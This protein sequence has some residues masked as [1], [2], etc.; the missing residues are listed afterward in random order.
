MK[1]YHLYQIRGFQKMTSKLISAALLSVCLFPF[2][3]RANQNPENPTGTAQGLRYKFYTGSTDSGVL[4]DFTALSPVKAGLI[5]NFLLDPRTTDTNIAFEYNGYVNCP[6]TGTWTFYTSSDDGSKLFIGGTQVVD[7]NFSQG[8]YERSGTIALNA[9]VHAIKVQWAQGGGALGLEVRYQGPSGTNPARTQIPNEALSCI[10]PTANPTFSPTNNRIMASTVTVSIADITPG[11]VIYYTTNGTTPTTSSSVYSAPLGPLTI[12]VTVKAIAKAPNMD[13]SDVVTMN[14]VT[15]FP[16]ANDNFASAALLTGAS[17]S[18]TGTNLNSSWESGEPNHGGGGGQRSIWY[19]WV[20][21]STGNFLISTASSAIDT[22]LGVYTGSAVNALTKVADNDDAAAGNSTSYVTIAAVSGTAYYFAID[23]FDGAE[24]STQINIGPGQLIS[25]TASTPTASE[26]TLSS[27][28]FTV[29][30][31]GN[32]AYPVTVYFDFSGTADRGLDFKRIDD[33]VIFNAGETVKTVTI[34]PIDDLIQEGN[35][36]VILT[37]LPSPQFA[38]SAAQKTATVTI[39]DNETGLSG[40]VK[41]TAFSINRGFYSAP[42][43]VAITTATAGASINYTLDGTMPTPTTGNSYSAPLHITSTT[44]LRAIAF[45]SGM[46][47][48]NVDTQTY[49]FTADIITQSPGGAPPPGWPLT[50]G[51]NVK[52]Y[53]MDQSVVSANSATIQNDIKTLPSFCVSIKLADLFDPNTGIY[54]NPSQDGYAWERPC[55]L[56]LIDPNNSA[57]NMGALCG[58]RLRGGFSRD[59]GNPKHAFRIFFR[60]D[61]DK[62]SLSYPLFG[63]NG[64]GTTGKGKIDTFDIRTFQNY[65]WSYQGDRANELF[66]RDVFSRDTQLAL[67]N[68]GTRGDYYHLYINGIYW[69]IYNTEE[70][71]EASYAANYYGGDKSDYDVV[72]S[73][74]DAGYTVYATDGNFDSWTRLWKQCKAGLSSNEAYFRLQGKNADGTPNPNYENLLEIDDLIDYMFVIYYGG[75]LDS[76]ISAFLGNTSPNNMFGFRSRTGTA[77]WRFTTHD[78]EHTL[79]NVNES[80]IGPWTAGDTLD[81]SNPQWFFQQCM[82]N[83]EF[84]IK[85]ADH[86]RRHFF[87]NGGLTAAACKARLQTRINQLDRAV[88]GESARWGDSKVTP[89]C[90]RADWLI[91]CGNVLTY[92]NT[93]SDIVLQQL[94]SASLYPTLAAPTF[95]QY[96]GTFSLPTTCTITNPNGTGTIYYTTNGADPRAIGG[97]STPGTNGGTTSKDVSISSS[98]TVRARILTGSTWSA[99]T[100]ATFSLPQDF[101]T[102]KVSEIMYNPPDLNGFPG[103][104]YEFIE[105]KNTGSAALNISNATFTSGITYTFPSGTTLAAGQIIVLAANGPQYFFKYPAAPAPFGIYSGRLNNSGDTLTLKASTGATIF[106]FA[107]GTDAPWPVA[108]DGNGFSIVPINVATITNPADGKQWRASTNIDGSPGVDD[109]VSTLATIYVNEVLAHTDLPN[110]DYIELYNPTGVPVDIT[111][112]YLTDDKHLPQKYKIS[113]NTIPAGGYLNFLDTLFNAQPPIGSNTPFRVDSHGEE[114]YVFSANSATGALTG[115]AHG[116]KFGATANPIA[117]G[118]YVI[119]TGAEHFVAQ[120]SNTPG[121]VNSGPAVGPIVISE[122]M[123]QPAPGVDEFIELLNIS[124]NTVP[125]YDVNNPAN[126]WKFSDGIDFTFPTN[127]SMA[128][129][130]MILI[131]GIAPSAY[132]TKYNIPPGIQIFGPW[133]GALSDNGETL[134]LQRPDTPDPILNGVVVVPYLRVDWLSYTNASPWPTEPGGTGPSLVR[135]SNSAYGNDPINWKKSSASGGTP[136]QTE[137]PLPVAPAGLTVVP[138]TNTILGLSWGDYSNTETSY[139]IERSPDGISGWVPVITLGANITSYQNSGLSANVTYYYRVYASNSFGNSG[140]SNV[141]SGTTYP[142]PAP[143]APA[144]LAVATTSQ[145]QLDLSWNDAADNENGFKVER[146]LDGVNNWIEIAQIAANSITYSSTGLAS[147]TFYF[148]RVRAYNVA[149][150]S[151]Y[152]NVS[153][154]KTQAPFSFVWNGGSGTWSAGTTGWDAGAWIDSN[155]ASIGKGSDTAGTLAISSIVFPGNITFNPPASGTY[156]VTGGTIDFNTGISIINCNASATISAVIANGGLIKNGPGRLNL[157]AANS[158]RGATTL[159]AG[160]LAING[161]LSVGGSPISIGASGAIRGIGTINRVVNTLTNT[162]VVWPGNSV[163]A[164]GVTANETLNVPSTVNMSTGTGGKFITLV[165]RAANKCQSLTCTTLTLGTNSILDIGYDDGA[166]I[167]TFQVITTTSPILKPFSSIIASK[168]TIGTQFNVLYRSDSTLVATNVTTGTFTAAQNVNNVALQFLANNVTPVTIDSFTA[169]AEGAG[170]LLT[171]DAV[172][173]FQNQGFNI[174]RRAVS[175]GSEWAKVNS[176]MIPGRLTNTQFK[177]Y[178]LYDWAAPGLYEYKLE[179]IALDGTRETFRD[180]ATANIDWTALNTLAPESVDAAIQANMSEAQAATAA[181]TSARFETLNDREV[182]SAGVVPALHAVAVNSLQR[183]ETLGPPASGRTDSAPSIQTRAAQETI[184]VAARWFSTA[185]LGTAAY[186]AAKVVYVAPG[187]LLIPQS[188]LPAG[189]DINHVTLQREGRSIT[190]LAVT[191][192]G[193]LIYAPGYQD[194]YT[195]KDA[196]SCAKPP[197]SHWPAAPQKHPDSSPLRPAPPL[198]HS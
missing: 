135:I 150:N 191:P 107:F 22:T 87:N 188:A 185:P 118:R 50:W 45:K 92:M 181:L 122:V 125:L 96:G 147:D 166:T 26:A 148:Y 121:T 154:A 90:T 32:S 140:F 167:G 114:V 7:N 126:T 134:E 63:P 89:A 164:G 85:V 21:P 105:L 3:A 93:R 47:P 4:P 170:T 180:A 171:W 139:S 5:T 82:A 44:T 40:T 157:T 20:A 15:G 48:T 76:P 123:Y 115:Y 131:V 58:I 165:N 49:L 179:T 68:Q 91:V 119:S 83:A 1:Q 176:A 38:L 84:R 159:N 16:P 133:S 128:P 169:R 10:P 43:D 28:V 108:A 23:G 41:D 98:V 184:S 175:D 104:E 144:S 146:S 151:P 69:G 116:F 137:S 94:T 138:V 190:A 124:V 13:L 112:W 172:S 129:N 74:A 192:E 9:G 53:G 163:G 52:D 36:T 60:K 145:T 37:L 79:L 182:K 158:F 149:G 174:Y 160:T 111:G 153:S 130:E 142:V 67:C 31:S 73:A 33:N 14:Y 100:E 59:T 189:F 62:G 161:S 162:S 72:K 39:I 51:G 97:A 6:V 8:M 120:I 71:P 81:K 99:L 187:I 127:I 195:D 75:N 30:R 35:E 64:Q 141:A 95:N 198:R 152:S 110:H 156:T 102:L 136:G 57:N 183:T 168:G 2:V 24:G 196:I 143:N 132:R 54:A 109:P 77:G 17:T 66:I 78:A 34:T 19:K 106:S 88:I 70:R 12:P 42:I 56:E 61:Y 46:N 193:I 197:G 155:N 194:D 11:A 80:R 117:L 103:S 27:G 177:T 113:S 29:T 173:E 86:I 25:V 186:T 178:A 18:A 65:S 101:T 55:S